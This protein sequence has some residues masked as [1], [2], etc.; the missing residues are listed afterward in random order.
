M[1]KRINL[2]F[3]VL[4][5]GLCFSCAPKESG[6]GP[7]WQISPEKRLYDS[8][9]SQYQYGEYNK[10]LSGFE[11]YLAQFPDSSLVPA[12]RL[13]IGMIHKLKRQYGK[14][15]TDFQQI[16]A[17]YPNAPYARDARLELLDVFYKTGDYEKVTVSAGNVLAQPLTAAQVYRANVITGDAYMA[18]K[19]P[20]DAYSSYLGAFHAATE[21]QATAIVSK[22]KTALALM[23]TADLADELEKLAGQP[24]SADVMFQLG[25]NYVKDGNAD[26]AT[27]ILS[28]F[29][30]QYPF[31]ENVD[32]AKQL[33]A[34]VKSPAFAENRK[35]IIGVL[36]PMTG[37]Y[38]TFGLQAYN[39]IEYAFSR[40]ATQ[41]GG[42]V[43]KILLKD[44]G[45]DLQKTRQA[46]KELAE[47]HA[48]AIIGPIGT[49]DEAARSAQEF[50]IPIIILTQKDGTTAIGDYVFRHFLTPRM[51][52]NAL[53]SYAVGALG[54]KRVAILYPAEN[55]GYIHMKAFQEAVIK[56][57]G[58]ITGA[59]AYPPRQTDFAAVIKKLAPHAGAALSS[60]TGK[61]N[62][63]GFS[64]PPVPEPDF[65]AI[66]I[67]DSP[68]KAGLII[69]QLAYYDVK[70]AVLL[71]TNLWHSDNFIQMTRENIQTAFITEGFFDKSESGHVRQFVSGFTSAYGSVPKFIEAISYDTAIML[72]ELAA[73][74]DVNDGEDIRREL[75]VMAPFEGVTGK[76]TFD[77][78]REAVKYITILKI[79]QGAFQEVNA[80]SPLYFQ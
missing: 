31:H 33:M 55:Y 29:V 19:S 63:T 26:D 69:P 58:I 5:I 22:L 57:G 37:K 16:I 71:G 48:A 27:A 52:V 68:E 79:S 40:F 2:I 65:D 76:T 20:Q 32:Q 59:E 44:T 53:A 1:T 21:K 64:S 46:V 28:A 41:E 14:A 11:S 24:P 56:A 77:E 10:A 12:S 3:S 30:S 39:G 25:V 80:S 66:F 62:E 34:E 54:L 18:L 23:E 43:I 38:A 8:A 6:P 47:N 9:E 4:I 15:Q 35:V 61:E 50:K 73:R 13:R 75:L 49:V 67:P 60:G 45:S 7:F 70:G 42:S 78:N 51:Q 36:L 17:A 72:F 74:S